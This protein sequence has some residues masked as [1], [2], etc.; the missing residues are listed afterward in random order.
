MEELTSKE[1]FALRREGKWREALPPARSLYAKEPGDEWNVRA[2][3]WCLVSGFYEAEGAEEK[4]DY[5]KELE[6]LPVL[7]EDELFTNSRKKISDRQDPLQQALFAAQTLSRNGDH[8]AAYN[9]LSRLRKE[10]G[11]S[12]DLDTS[13]AWEIFRLIN[14]EL[15]NNPPHTERVTSLLLEYAKLEVAKPSDIHSRL[16]DVAAR[17]ASKEVFPRF[18][19]FFSWWDSLNFQAGDFKQ[20][21]APDGGTYPSTVEKV[22]S[23]LGK[24]LKG[25]ED[26]KRIQCTASFIQKHYLQY[27]DQEWFPYYLALAYV[28]LGNRD[29]ALPILL[30]VVRAKI[31]EFWAW[32]HLA[33]C[34]ETQDPHHLKCLFRALSCRVPSEEFLLNVRLDLAEVLHASDRD[35]EAGFE[36]REVLNI[37]KQHE[38]SLKHREQALSTSPWYRALDGKV[39]QADYKTGSRGSDDILLHD[40]PKHSAV[41]AEANIKIG[42]KK[43]RRHVLDVAFQ[44]TGEVQSVLVPPDL[45]SEEV[46]LEP[47]TPITV[48]VDSQRDHIRVLSVNKRAGERWDILPVLKGLLFDK[49]VKKYLSV[50]MLEDG[51]IS[52]CHHRDF[53]NAEELPIGTY[54]E[55]RVSHDPKGKTKLRDFS[56]TA[57]L[58][59]NRY[60]KSFSGTFRPREDDRGGG[61]HVGDM[62]IPRQLV[63]FKEPPRELKGIAVK[64]EGEGSRDSWWKAVT[65]LPFSTT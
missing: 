44:D 5:A 58:A 61:G 15:R 29:E 36:V 8:H 25:E 16:L 20:E 39:Q 13:L 50:V 28:K 59:D 33:E 26:Q 22:I 10:K 27:P 48:C 37:K 11:G 19:G 56:A 51:G 6:S 1:I 38:W 53:P 62:F 32:G 7:A 43:L 47:G 3:G 54:L 65:A 17:A 4:K 46:T 52:I 31:N 49:N 55:C 41:L 14:E 9:E 40:L 18:C 21:R 34:F 35:S 57:P 23:A 45:V 64:Q 30:P 63:N 12:L 42:E 2:F 60:W 24:S